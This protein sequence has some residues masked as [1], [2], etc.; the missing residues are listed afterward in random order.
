MV[1]VLN[2]IELEIMTD[3]EFYYKEFGFDPEIMM[4]VMMMVII[5]IIAAAAIRIKG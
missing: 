5:V 2:I 1:V 3:F 4:I